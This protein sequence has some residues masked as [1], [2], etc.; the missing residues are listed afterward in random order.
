MR[1]LIFAAL[2]ASIS[3]TQTHAAGVDVLF[4]GNVTSICVLAL[5]T[6][7]NLVPDTTGHLASVIPGTVTILTSGG[8][9]LKIA[10]PVWDLTPTSPLYVVGGETFEYS[11]LGLAG[12]SIA[13]S[14][15]LSTEST[16][17]LP[18]LPLSIMTLNARV[19]SPSAFVNGNYRLKVNV[20]CVPTGT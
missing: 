19:S 4:S 17:P 13:A 18:A 2:I 7:G 14:G 5:G 12:A 1:K 9:S 6:P 10:A 8:N 11:Y 16:L 15:W 3:T 20:T